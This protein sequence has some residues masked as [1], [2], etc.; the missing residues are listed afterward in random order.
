STKSA[1]PVVAEQV[2]VLIHGSTVDI[3]D[4]S[5]DPTFLEALPDDMR[6][7]VLSQHVCNQ[8]AARVECPAD[9]QISSESLNALPPEISAKIIQQEAAQRAC[10]PNSGGPVEIDNA[11]FLA[12]LDLTLCQT[13]L[14]A[15]GE[16]FIQTLPSHIFAEA[17]HSH[18]LAIQ[19]AAIW[20]PSI[21]GLDYCVT[22]VVQCNTSLI[23]LFFVM[24]SQYP[25]VVGYMLIN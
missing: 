23:V 21:P 19:D 16:E 24:S 12:R 5:I 6:E 14:M 22:L 20:G 13:V 7:E 3:T 9:S 4:T 8:C 2:M 18:W 25:A 17:E 11:S 15:Q 1:A 10:A